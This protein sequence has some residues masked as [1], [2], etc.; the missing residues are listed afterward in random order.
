MIQQLLDN[1]PKPRIHK[2]VE[3]YKSGDIEIL[4]HEYLAKMNHVLK[5]KLVWQRNKDWLAQIK[6]HIQNGNALIVVG[7][8]HLLG[9][10]SIIALLQKDGYIIHREN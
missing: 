7:A 2:M 9:E 6:H 4:E 8:L 10:H 1:D 3:A 5:E